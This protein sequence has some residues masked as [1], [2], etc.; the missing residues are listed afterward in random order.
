M[1]VLDKSIS[2][3]EDVEGGRIALLR[4]KCKTETVSLSVMTDSLQS[5]SLSMAFPRQEYSIGLPFPSPGDSPNPGIEP[6][7][8]ALQA[9]SL[10]SELPGK[11]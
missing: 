7:S 10:P 2:N 9:D 4:S 6:G 3:L 11:P 1:H 8:P 5:H